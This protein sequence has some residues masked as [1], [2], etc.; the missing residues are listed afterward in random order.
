MA[1]H[2]NLL[3]AISL[4][5]WSTWGLFD[6]KAL[7]DAGH[8]DVLLFQHFFYLLEVPLGWLL[9]SWLNH[10]SWQI[11]SQTWF[12]TALG[13]LASST[14]TLFYLIAMSRAEASFVLG[15]TAGYPL[16]VQL[17]AKIFLHEPLVPE[18]LWG[19]LLVGLGVALIGSTSSA[20]TGTSAESVASKSRKHK[21]VLLM[22]LLATLLW[23]ATGLF[24]KKALFYDEPFKVFYSRSIWDAVFL[25]AL[26]VIYRRRG[27]KIAWSN[28]TAW[29]YSSLSAF[30]LSL[31][32]LTYMFAMTMATASYVIVITGCYPLLMYLGAV[33]FLKEKLSKMRLAGVIFVVLGGLMVQNTQSQ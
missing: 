10:G 19:S 29:K 12:W 33:I 24:D 30:C 16:V 26:L 5:C 23:G 4:L 22:C 6:K 9:I 2:L 3:I 17:L 13:T 20:K 27:Y 8:L 15:I 21:I 18:R 28:S 11:S 31:G 32:T 1:M 14:A 25:A 7:D